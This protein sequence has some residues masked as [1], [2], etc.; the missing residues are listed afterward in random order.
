MKKRILAVMLSFMLSLSLVPAGQAVVFAGGESAAEATTSAEETTGQLVSEEPTAKV[1]TPAAETPEEPTAEVTTLAAETPEESAD[2]ATTPTD[3]ASSLRKL[4][5]GDPAVSDEDAMTI[6]FLGDGFTETEQE[7]FFSYAKEAS[8]YLMEFAPWNE[9]SRNI[10]IYAIGTP[11]ND[12]GVKGDSASN[13]NEA[14]ADERDTYFGASYWSGGSQRIMEL[15]KEE[16]IKAVKEEYGIKSSADVV[17]VNS[18]VEGGTAYWSDFGDREEVGYV[19]LSVDATMKNCTVHELGHLVAWLADE[20]WGGYSGDYYVNMDQESDPEKVKWARYIGMEGIGVYEYSGA[21]AGWYHPSQTCMMQILGND[22]CAVCADALRDEIA[23]RSNVVNMQ[24]QTY[25]DQFY[26]R[27]GKDMSEYFILRQGEN[28]VTGD[29]VGEALHLTYYDSEGNVVD[30]IPD[31]AGDYTVK[32]VF[33]GN[34]DFDACEQSG[35]YTIQLPNLITINVSD[36]VYDG[37]PV[38]MTYTVDGYDESEYDAVVTYTGTFPYSKDTTQTYESTEAPVIQG[39]YTVTV[40]VYEKGTEEL[41]T[42]KSANFEI[43]FQTVPIVYNSDPEWP[44]ADSSNSNFTYYIF[45]D[46]YTAEEEEKFLAQATEFVQNFLLQEPYRQMSSNLNFIAVPTPSNTSG[47]SDPEGDTYFGLSYD[48]NGTIN[49]SRNAGYLTGNICYDKLDPYYRTAIVLVNDENAVQGSYY[50]DYHGTVFATPDEAGAEYAARAASEIFISGYYN[51]DPIP[52]DVAERM[53]YDLEGGYLEEQIECYLEWLAYGSYTMILTDVYNADFV[54]NGEPVDITDYLHTYN[55][56]IEIPN[57]M[58]E[59]AI[60]YYA[61]D[62]G[63]IG[64]ALDGAPSEAGTYHAF[65]HHVW[66]DVVWGDRVMTNPDFED[67]GAFNP[68]CVSKAWVTFTI[69]PEESDVTEPGTDPGTEPGTDPGTEPGTNPGTEPGTNPGKD[70]NT[71]NTNANNA[72]DT[73]TNTSANHSNVNKTDVK[74][75]KTGDAA[76]MTVW[77]LLLAGCVMVAGV[78]VYRRKSAK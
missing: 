56:S 63:E 48:E 72:A 3:E 7:A 54:E 8:A 29:E 28:K 50:V 12:S 6:L 44:G 53:T 70:P 76:D 49:A 22:L 68:L 19:I 30:G 34:E 43:G 40:E 46:G 41:I 61:D 10:K 18:Q 47:I 58:L 32:A 2:T 14:Q 35:T 11:S 26:A 45:G 39:N 1:T 51:Y 13:Y 15:G 37:N 57:S 66:D 77:F 24:F 75:V 21:G 4:Y 42:R 16:N 65:V 36:K 5:D 59:Y 17:L 23:A 52:E 9:F 38:E 67:L 20:Y 31:E 62:N 64:E 71:D 69:N 73:K 74:T 60:T 55:A 25:G 33:D 27:E 78:T